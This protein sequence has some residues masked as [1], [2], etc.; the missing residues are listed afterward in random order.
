[1]QTQSVI[2]P[3]VSVEQVSRC[4]GTASDCWLVAWH[5]RNLGQH[6]LRLLAARLPHSWFRSEERELVPIPH[7]LPGER[8]QLEFPVTC[9]GLPGSV[10][11]NA[12]LIVR[13]LW[14]EEPWRVFARLRVVFDEQGGP[15]TTTEV[16]TVQR[17][18][19][20]EDL[21]SI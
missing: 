4:A 14:Q 8:A 18:G 9:S 3:Q 11:E 10:V 15:Q 17:V 16:V 7:L 5:I 1:M 12:F 21:K 19:F 13:V 20:S 2:G 6:P